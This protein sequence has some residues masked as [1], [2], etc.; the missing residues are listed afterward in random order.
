MN[1]QIIIIVID[2]DDF[3]EYYD[4][5]QLFVKVKAYVRLVF[6]ENGKFSS[7]YRN[8]T[9]DFLKTNVDSLKLEDGANVVKCYYCGSSIDVTKGKCE[10]CDSD[11]KYLQEWVLKKQQ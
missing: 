4:G 11:I 7:Q 1:Q 8:D 5:D 9:Y 3:S 10:Y 2:Y 6:F